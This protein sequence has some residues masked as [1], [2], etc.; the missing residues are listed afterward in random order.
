MSAIEETKSEIGVQKKAAAKPASAASI[1]TKVLD[2]LSS[3]RFGVSLLILLAS[4]CMVG[5]L[6]MQQNIEGFENYYFNLSPASRLLFGGLGFF[7]IYHAWYFHALLLVLSLN[8]VLASIDR[9]PKAWTFVSKPKLDASAHWLRGQEQSATF[10]MRGETVGAVAERIASAFTTGGLKPVVTEKAGK[11]FVFGQSGTWNRLGAYAVHV[12]LLTI[13]FGGFLTAKFGF[14]G[15][16]SLVPGGSANKIVERVLELDQPRLQTMTLPFTVECTDIQQKLIRKD[17]PITAD[18]T[19]D[20]LTTVRI[21]DANYGESEGVVH[22]NAPHDFSRGWFW[23]NYRFFQSSFVP[24]G[25]A[26]Q[27][28]LRVAP[29]A[30]GPAEDVIIP[31]DGSATLAD[32]TRIDFT[33]FSAQFNL[34]RE[35]VAAERVVYTNPAATL[36]VRPPSGTPVKAIAFTPA[37]AENAPI[38]KRPVAGYTY[39][40]VDFEKVPA[41]HILSVQRDPGASVVYVGFVL[42]GLTLCAVFFFSHRRV[43]AHVAESGAG[44]YEV[45]LGGNTNRNRLGFEDRFKKIV[46]AAGGQTVEVKQS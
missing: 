33:D 6:V 24:D 28:T 43:W 19:L 22:M 3:V 10:S 12:A 13:F 30:G 11:T 36:L 39:R 40:L 1:P 46:E 18:N 17:G 7:D 27:I 9:F 2:F 45:T 21:K 26:R 5:M 14:T 44:V 4:A 23:D 29:E 20:W 16:M 38:A 31:R 25:K 41:G 15:N 35:E 42:L 8:I 32:G 34:S 37:M